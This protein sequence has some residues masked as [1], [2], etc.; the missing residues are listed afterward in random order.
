MF[1]VKETYAPTLL[2]RRTKKLQQETGD[3]RW[4]CQFDHEQTGLQMLKT[5][6]IR[7][8]RMILFEPIW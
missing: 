4:W 3:L 8:I 7:P 6:L 2:R 1:L 5:N